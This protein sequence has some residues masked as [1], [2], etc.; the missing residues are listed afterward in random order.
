[1]GTRAFGESGDRGMVKLGSEACDELGNWGI[2]HFGNAGIRESWNWELG[3]LGRIRTN[4]NELRTFPP[5]KPRCRS[6]GLWVMSSTRKPLRHF[7]GWN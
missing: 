5:G 1:M 6:S 4:K 7:A 3:G 2:G